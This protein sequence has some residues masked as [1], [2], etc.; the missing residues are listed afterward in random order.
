VRAASS[1]PTGF[2]I[3]DAVSHNHI[4]TGS[5]PMCARDTAADPLLSIA[6]S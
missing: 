2:I 5:T 1:T 6:Y 4:M 3:Y